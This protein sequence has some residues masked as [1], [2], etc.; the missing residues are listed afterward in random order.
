MI[1]ID[2]ILT[3]LRRI[4][5]E[6][7]KDYLISDKEKRALARLTKVVEEFGEFSNE[8][9]ASMNLQNNKKL[10]SFKKKNLE[11]EFSDVLITLMLLGIAL[12]IEIEKALLSRIKSIKIS[13]D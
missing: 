8:V 5:K 12:D 13:K 3:K 2:E 4:N 1:T 9:L 10:K 11:K 7:D 6:L